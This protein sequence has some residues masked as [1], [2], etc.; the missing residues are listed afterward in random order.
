MTD[1]MYRKIK[2][3]SNRFVDITFV[4][5][6]SFSDTISSFSNIYIALGQSK[7]EGR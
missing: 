7:Q 2:M 3:L 4:F 1:R 5:V 6:Y